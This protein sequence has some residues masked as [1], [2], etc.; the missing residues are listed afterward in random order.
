MAN[1]PGGYA[2][3]GI[4]PANGLAHV[5]GTTDRPLLEATI[6]AFL[7]EVVRR[8]GARDAAVFRQPGVRWTY[9]EFARAVDRLA[10]GLLSIGVYRGDRVG[11]W[12]PNRPEWLLTQFATARI[13]AILVNINPAYQSSELEYALNKVGVK[14]LIL[15]PRFKAS[16]YAG[17]I[18][19]LAPELATSAPGRLQAARLPALRAVIE[20]GPKPIPGAFAFASVKKRGTP[21]VRARLDAIT[22]ML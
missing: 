18:A 6:P 14:A 2:H 16:D 3:P 11:I 9:A 20:L 10:A 15:A 21:G 17:T 12:A 19:A 5:R 1:H 7:A 8:H 13:G 4:V 22:A